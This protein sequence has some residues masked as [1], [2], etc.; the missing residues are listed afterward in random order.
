MRT[1]RHTTV[2]RTMTAIVA[3]T[4]IAATAACSSDSAPSEN[5]QGG[6]SA[7]SDTTGTEDAV[8]GAQADAEATAT[9]IAG[10][11]QKLAISGSAAHIT[12]SPLEDAGDTALKV[13]SDNDKAAVPAVEETDSG[14]SVSFDLLE[15]AATSAVTVYIHPDAQWTITV[16]APGDSLTADFSALQVNELTLNEGYATAAVT[17]PTDSDITINQDGSVG[18][19]TVTTPAN[20]FVDLSISAGFGAADIN[21]ETI[22]GSDTYSTTTGE[23]DGTPKVIVTNTAGLGKFTLA[24][25]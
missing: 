17:T 4:L 1:S 19:F 13:T 11:E 23:K 15:Q 25:N 7:Q 2:T 8:K 14:Y 16:D 3:V 22:E 6:D 21:G 20:A 24:S 12:I 10:S 9:D 18:D 5:T